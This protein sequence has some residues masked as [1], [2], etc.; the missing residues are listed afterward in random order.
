V[1]LALSPGLASVTDPDQSDFLPTSYESV[2]AGQVASRDFPAQAGTSA[3]LAVWRPDRGRLTSADQSAVSA[4]AASLSAAGIDRVTAVQTSARQISPD[5]TVQLVQIGLDGSAADPAVNQAVSALR[6]GAARDLRGTGLT[7]G[8]TGPAAIAA[9]TAAANAAAARIVAVAT[10]VLILVLLG[11]IFRS[12]LVALLPVAAVAL[13]YAVVTSVLAITARAMHAEIT[14]TLSTLLIVVLFGVGTDYV[15]FLLFR[16]REWLRGG[17]GPVDALALAEGTAGEA[18]ASAAATVMAAFA[19]LLLSSLG[20]L[21][22]MGPGLVIAVATMLLAALTL[23]PALCSLL[24]SRLFWPAGARAAEPRPSGPPLSHRLASWIVRHRVLAAPVVAVALAGLALGAHGYA[25]SYDSL[26]DL[27]GQAESLTAYDRVTQ[28]LPAGVVEPTLVYVEA[29]AA[30]DPTAVQALRTRLMGVPGVAAVQPPQ[31]N[32]SGT[33]AELTVTLRA[34][35]TSSGALGPVAALRDAAH[36]SVLGA[37]VLVGGTTAQLADVRSSFDRDLTVVF[38]VAALIILLILAGFLRSLV[39]PA[40]VLGVVALGF[41]A[42]LGVTVAVFQGILG[43]DGLDFTIPIVLYLFV[44]AIGTD[45]GILIMSRLREAAAVTPNGAVAAARAL[46]NAGPTIAAAAVVLAGTF[47]SLLLTGIRSLQEIGVGV[48]AGVLIAAFLAAGVLIPCLTAVLGDRAWWPS[49]PA[50]P[51]AA[52]DE[53]DALDH[54]RG[55]N[56]RSISQ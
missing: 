17:H 10:I 18:I 8:L 32:A 35:P 21:R 42:S 16:Y 37:S 14:A 53:P 22:S 51:D 41:A 36:G 43:G 46:R 11:A 34:D 28:S 23:V 26:A 56:T 55:M 29:P 30:L 7:G 33:A 5:G 19:A 13:V 47:A 3:L 31:V 48:A 27:P 15:V 12:P 24:G 38:P 39:A 9:D 45:Y 52:R 6:A 44:V 2:Q 54:V 20:S 4:L 50:R 1:L 40:Y 25:A 49:R